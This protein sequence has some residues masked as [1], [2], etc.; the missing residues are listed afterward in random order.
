VLGLSGSSLLKA[1][2]GR[3]FYGLL[4]HFSRSKLSFGGLNRL[5]VPVW[6]LFVTAAKFFPAGAK[7]MSSGSHYLVRL[8]CHFHA[9]VMYRLCP[10]HRERPFTSDPCHQIPTRCPNLCYLSFY[11]SGPEKL[12]LL[13]LFHHLKLT[14]NVLEQKP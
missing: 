5:F 1:V 10:E 4:V 14:R 6:S 12:L 8:H 9:C 7:S 2:A 13:V 11:I 3:N